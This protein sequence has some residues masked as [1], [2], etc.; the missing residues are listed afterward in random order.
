[1][2]P[3]QLSAERHEKRNSNYLFWDIRERKV[4]TSIKFRDNQKKK[5]LEG[6]KQIFFLPFGNSDYIRS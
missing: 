6:V 3:K 1:M 4:G 5:L 2:T